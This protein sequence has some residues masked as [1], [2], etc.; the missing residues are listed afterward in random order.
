MAARALRTEEIIALVAAVALHLALVVA[1]LVRP[2]AEPVPLP[3]RVTVSL[4][5]DVGL[6]AMSPQPVPESRE[7][8]APTLSDSPAPE[9]TETQIAPPI[10]APRPVATSA[11][12]RPAVSREPRRRPDRPESRPQPRPQPQPRSTPTRSGGSRIGADFLPGSGSSTSTEETRAPAAVF[13][14]AEQAALSQAINRQLKPHWRAP[15]GLETERLVTVLTWRMNRDGSLANTPTVVS[16][17][18]ITDANRAQAQVHA[19]RAIRAVQLAAPF[20]LPD[21]FYDKWN[22]I[23]DWRFDR[24]L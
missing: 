5:E 16:Q 18:G 12:T 21:E 3:E 2:P 19:E 15:Q 24:R 14:R 7:A 17:S 20:N 6:E 13:G 1:M 10:P 9:V 22:Y 4:A 23:R 8:V 11:P